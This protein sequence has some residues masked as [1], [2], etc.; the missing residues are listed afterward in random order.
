MIQLLF[1]GSFLTIELTNF[2][3]AVLHLLEV[4]PETSLTTLP[5]GNEK[6][7]SYFTH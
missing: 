1:I 6:I 4:K 5:V 7:V 3:T 2:A